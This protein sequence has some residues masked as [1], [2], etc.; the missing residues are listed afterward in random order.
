MPP[1]IRLGLWLLLI[2]LWCCPGGSTAAAYGPPV[3]EVPVPI[4]L[5]AVARRVL[6]TAP[7]VGI[8]REKITQARQ[9]HHME[10]A[11]LWPQANLNASLAREYNNPFL[12]NAATDVAASGIGPFNT[13]QTY[14][15]S[16]SQLLFDGW[17]SQY[18]IRSSA[19]TV[20]ATTLQADQIVEELLIQTLEA[21]LGLAEN[22]ERLRLARNTLES[23]EH[24]GSLVTLRLDSGAGTR[25]EKSY[26]DARIANI[27]A[28]ILDIESAINDARTDLAR[29]AGDI[30]PLNATFPAITPPA[31]SL[32]EALNQAMAS[33]RAYQRILA[34]QQSLYLRHKSQLAA[35]WPTLSLLL[36]ANSA[37]DTGGFV[38]RDENIAA[39][40][41]V[42]FQLYD[43]GTR[44]AQA[45][46]IL[47]QIQE[48]KLEQQ[49][50]KDTLHRQLR[51]IYHTLNSKARE[52]DILA[53]EIEASNALRRLHLDNFR[54]GDGS[55]S[56]LVES[57]ERLFA[58]QSRKLAAQSVRIQQY[59]SYLLQTGTLIAHFDAPLAR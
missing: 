3:A 53:M 17:K 23:L 41:Q 45:R 58:A 47:S 9:D 40:L 16:A 29:L 21:Y 24:I 48:I 6:E 7:E 22:Q 27:R 44:H 46:K 33:N 30:P 12:S 36:D 55:I 37:Y 4:S 13:A 59:F 18:A 38:G 49:R 32:D 25:A 56:Q 19:E 52:L 10:K 8:A 50:T 42:S 28:A 43:G 51:Q 54:L 2:C 5:D 35:Y 14:G 20:T 31:T 11:A 34:E 26:V 57:E 15:F 1:C 39:R